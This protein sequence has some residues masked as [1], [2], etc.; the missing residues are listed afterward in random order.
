MRSSGSVMTVVTSAMT[1]IIVNSGVSRTPICLPT[2]R[3]T[4]SVGPRVFI[5]AAIAMLCQ[6]GIRWIRAP[7]NAPMTFPPIAT[8]RIRRSC[9][10]GRK[11]TPVKIAGEQSQQAWAQRDARDDLADDGRLPDQLRDSPKHAGHDD[12][13]CYVEHEDPNCV[14][15]ASSPQP[16]RAREGR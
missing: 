4:N 12:D 3:M 10:S 16:Y 2:I 6:T 11:Q 5:S 14:A 9:H 8:A 15:H 1:T 13:H 7:T